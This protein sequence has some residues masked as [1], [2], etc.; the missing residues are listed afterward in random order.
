M[1]VFSIPAFTSVAQHNITVFAYS[2]LPLCLFL[3]AAVRTWGLLL[4]N[5]VAVEL[6]VELSTVFR[7][8]KLFPIARR[9]LLQI[10]AGFR[11]FAPLSFLVV[12]GRVLSL[13][14]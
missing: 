2:N 7:R 11:L 14:R 12:L 9:I 1:L 6:F 13:S 5:A 4:R 8:K 10:A 3:C